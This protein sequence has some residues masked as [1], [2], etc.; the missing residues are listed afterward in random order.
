M[1]APSF[2]FIFIGASAQKKVRFLGNKSNS[3]T[4]NC[5]FKIG[6]QTEIGTVIKT[7]DKSYRLDDLNFSLVNATPSELRLK[8]NLY[9][10]EN[11]EPGEKIGSTS[12]ID[13][14][15]PETGAISLDISKYSFIVK[16]DFFI[17]I[18][19]EEAPAKYHSLFFAA[20]LLKRGTFYRDASDKAWER[21][22]PTAIGFNLA[23][24]RYPE[25]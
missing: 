5:S 15:V 14:K 17:A 16:K 10:I 11:N 9:S 18:E 2:I 4:T 23:A 6:R 13:V 1:L 12:I 22:A 3:K 20:V 7:G 21:I 19:W 8:V 25:K 24:E